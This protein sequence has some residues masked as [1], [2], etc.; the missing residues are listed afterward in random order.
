MAVTR[1]PSQASPV[2]GSYDGELNEYLGMNVE[3]TVTSGQAPPQT[4]IAA[5]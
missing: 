5:E 1:D 2:S 3:V 4:Q